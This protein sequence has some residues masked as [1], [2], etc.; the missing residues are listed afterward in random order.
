M[1]AKV[2]NVSDEAQLEVRGKLLRKQELMVA[3]KTGHVSI[4]LWDM[5]VA[6]AS[7]EK[8]YKFTDMSVRNYNGKTLS[9]TPVTSITRKKLQVY[10]HER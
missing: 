7:Q 9:T 8:S 10:R 4:T 1:A 6:T 5:L 3:D 2:L